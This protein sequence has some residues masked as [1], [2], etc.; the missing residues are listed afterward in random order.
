MLLEAT[1]GT[2]RVLTRSGGRRLW[3]LDPNTAVLWDLHRTGADLETVSAALTM[4][5]GMELPNAREYL[6]QLH[7]VWADGGLLPEAKEGMDGI[8]APCEA[9]VTFPEP[10]SRDRSR[11]AL[12]IVVAGRSIMVEVLSPA[13]RPALDPWIEPLIATS[14]MYGPAVVDELAILGDLAHWSLS[15]NGMEVR[16]GA[17]ESELTVSLIST[18]TEL[19]CRSAERLLVVH[20][21]GLVSPDGHGVLLAA[22]GGS[23]KTTLTVALEAEG[24]RLLSDDV[25]PVSLD[26]SALGLGLPACLKRGSWP[27]LSRWRPDLE[28]M[29]ITSRLGEDV[30]YLQP[31]HR[32]FTGALQPSVLLFPRY[33][34]GS[35]ACCAA[36]PPETALRRLVEADAV[37]RDLTQ[38]KLHLLCSWVE[39]LPAFDVTYPGL[40]EG[41]ELVRGVIGTAGK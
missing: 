8:D 29:K 36:V 32:P 28:R 41:L 9:F 3:L 22:P 20:G 39:R 5:F 30:R 40:S 26:G 17:G 4:R 34:P 33:S 10:R 12:Q 2:A 31:R 11:E 19:G 27:I 23:G 25:V 13:L 35:P 18:L 6:R 15:V 37:I 1:V 21:A 38:S 14:S 16:R 7:A 24:Y